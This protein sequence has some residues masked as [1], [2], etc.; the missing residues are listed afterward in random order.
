MGKDTARP[1]MS[2]CFTHL[3]TNPGARTSHTTPLLGTHRTPPICQ[4][5]LVACLPL[6][7]ARFDAAVRTMGGEEWRISPHPVLYL[8]ELQLH[9]QV[10]Q[11]FVCTFQPIS[12]SRPHTSCRCMVPERDWIRANGVCLGTRRRCSP[13]KQDKLCPDPAQLDCPSSDCTHR[14]LLREA[15]SCSAWASK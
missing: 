10:P 5:H 2:K 6:L 7:Q 8:E 15:D 13:D 1:T 12:P 11:H 9:L 3:T 14:P 4:P